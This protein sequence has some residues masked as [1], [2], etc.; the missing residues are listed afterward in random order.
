MTEHPEEPTEQADP[1]RREAFFGSIKPK[2]PREISVKDFLSLWGYKRRGSWITKAIE[3]E[4]LNRG[5]ASLPEIAKADYYGRVRILDRRDLSATD[6]LEVGWPISSV[7][8]DERELV[9]AALDDPLLAVE[10]EMLTRDYSQIPILSRGGRELH[11]S[12]TWKSLALCQVPRKKATARQAMDTRSRT[13]RSND[14]LLE[15]IGSIV[16][17]DFLYI[18]DSTGMY[19][20]ILT[21]TDLAESFHS[22]SGP[23]I[24]LGEIEH[25]LRLLINRFPLNVIQGAQSPSSEREVLSAADLNFGGYVR[26][27]EN[28]DN[29]NQLGLP[30]DRATVVRNLREVN[31]LRNDVMHF[32]PRPLDSQMTVAIDRCLNWIRTIPAV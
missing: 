7:L 17:N 14:P 18:R 4:L 8:D 22:A 25:R 21:A 12:V 31:E 30:L 26:I 16:V 5:L 24:K 11:G 20:G 10:T 15:H 28:R 27:I 23:F 19:V 3:R 29:W 2:S 13:A 9:S 32:R 6:D 1:N